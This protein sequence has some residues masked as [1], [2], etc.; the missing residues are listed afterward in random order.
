[1]QIQRVSA[2]AQCDGDNVRDYVA[3]RGSETV[4]TVPTA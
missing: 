2:Q 3:D 4:H 1:M